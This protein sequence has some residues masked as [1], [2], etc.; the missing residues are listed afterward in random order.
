M[1]IKAAYPNRYLRELRLGG[2][3]SPMRVHWMLGLN[4]E[5]RSGPRDDQY[6][7]DYGSNS[8]HRDHC[9]GTIRTIAIRQT[10][11]TKSRFR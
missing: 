9:G 7:F 2:L 1:T 8:G 4:Y 11:D 6:G 10:I 5:G 3:Q